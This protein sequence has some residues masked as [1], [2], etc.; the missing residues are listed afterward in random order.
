[1]HTINNSFSLVFF[2]LSFSHR[3]C[4]FT[5]FSLDVTIFQ[6]ICDVSVCVISIH[7]IF[8]PF[9]SIFIENSI[10][11]LCAMRILYYCQRI[12]FFVFRKNETYIIVQRLF[13]ISFLCHKIFVSCLRVL[14]QHYCVLYN[15]RTSWNKMNNFPHFRA[16]WML[17]LSSSFC[18]SSS[19]FYLAHRPQHEQF[20]LLFVII[21]KIDVGVHYTIKT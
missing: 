21:V 14:W 4:W 8:H 9:V 5:H 15:A 1:M 3:R 7:H 2:F 16:L 11:A 19:I 12:S 17:A 18:S 10:Y 20:L 6:F 13:R